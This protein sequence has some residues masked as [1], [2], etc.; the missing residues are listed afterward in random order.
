M[1]R[2]LTHIH[3]HTNAQRVSFYYF[4]YF[5]CFE[6]CYCSVF[7]IPV[8]YHGSSFLLFAFSFCMCFR[9]LD[10]ST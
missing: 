4:F 3:T 5:Y 7:S 9:Q 8:V 6:R 10:P 1:L 2:M